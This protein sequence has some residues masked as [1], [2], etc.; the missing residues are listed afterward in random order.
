MAQRTCEK[1]DCTVAA[2]GMCLLSHANL[3]DCPH[4][5]ADESA[6][7]MITPDVTPVTRRCLTFGG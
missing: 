5:R 1:A 4:F 2:T 6:A 7:D 3:A